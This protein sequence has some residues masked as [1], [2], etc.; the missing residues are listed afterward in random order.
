LT[1]YS[2][3]CKSK[4]FVENIN[5]EEDNYG[6]KWSLKALR[7]KYKQLNINDVKIFKKINKIII[8]TLIAVEKPMQS[9]Y[10][11][12]FQNRNNFYELYGFDILIDKKLKPWLL[13]VNIYPSL[14]I[15]TPMD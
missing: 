14:N 4:E 2:I 8:K 11:S 10:S 9:I 15:P 1:N 3:N 7:K 12:S 5:A 13:E 6:N